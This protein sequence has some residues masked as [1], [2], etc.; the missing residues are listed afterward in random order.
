MITINKNVCISRTNKKQQEEKKP[1]QIINFDFGLKLFHKPQNSVL[2]QIL[3]TFHGKN[4][5]CF[6]FL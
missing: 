6:H 4:L 2:D 5:K 3:S 1:E